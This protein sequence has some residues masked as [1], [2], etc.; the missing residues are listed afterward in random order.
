MSNKEVTFLLVEDDQIDIMIFERA[1]KKLKIANPLVVCKNGVEALNLLRGGDGKE[2]LKRPYIILLD[3][4]MPLMNGLEFLENLRQDQSLS[5]AVVFVLTTSN[6][7][8]DKYAAYQNHVAGYI[9]KS[10]PSRTF[11]DA[12][13]MLDK[14]WRIVEL[15]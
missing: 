11:L 6:N 3:L 13:A 8:S 5:S 7:E 9:L 2:A 15:P 14:Y 1:F 12:L 10:D 4:N